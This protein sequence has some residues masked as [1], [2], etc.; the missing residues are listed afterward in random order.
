MQYKLPYVHC[1]IDLSSVLDVL[2]IILFVDV[3][4]FAV[5]VFFAMACTEVYSTSLPDIVIL[6]CNLTL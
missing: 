2:I 6:H 1:C 3:N 4:F 5:V